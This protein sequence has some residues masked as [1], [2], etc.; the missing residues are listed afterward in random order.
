M[1][2]SLSVLIGI[3]GG[4]EPAAAEEMN[5]RAPA[6]GIIIGGVAN[7]DY[8]VGA[9]WHDANPFGVGA[10]WTE[11]SQFGDKASLAHIE[12]AACAEAIWIGL[13]YSAT[14]W[15]GGFFGAFIDPSDLGSADP[16]ERILGVMTSGNTTGG[17]NNIS[18]LLSS[19]DTYELSRAGGGNTE[20]NFVIS[21]PL[22]AG[23]IRVNCVKDSTT[24]TSTAVGSSTTLSGRPYFRAIYVT[25]N[26]SPY[27]RI[28]RLRGIYAYES[29]NMGA[30][31]QDS[32][33]NDR[34]Y[35]ISGSDNGDQAWV[36][37]NPPP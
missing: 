20:S 3:G 13:R 25:H 16:T 4:G 27:L 35:V 7:T 34:G 6:A 19:T 8:T 14:L 37:G 5:G 23:L 24:R 28:G 9:N 12:V 2:G 26:T 29:A 11:F 10:D 31:I 22:G 15:L 30:V 17:G 32:G 1:N 33:L 21:N 18:G 36:L